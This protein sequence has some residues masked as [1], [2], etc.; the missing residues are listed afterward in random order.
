MRATEIRIPGRPLPVA[1]E[2]SMASRSVG[3][4]PKKS[5][6]PKIKTSVLPRKKPAIAPV[7]VPIR[8]AMRVLLNP[9]SRERR[10]P[11]RIREVMSRPRESVPSQ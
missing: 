10:V 7:M 5:I 6:T 1:I 4:V 11:W 3:K 8:R 9:I 2:T